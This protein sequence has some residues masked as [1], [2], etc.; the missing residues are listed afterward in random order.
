MMRRKV[1]KNNVQCHWCDP[2]DWVL[3]WGQFKSWM[4]GTIL[5]FVFTIVLAVI[6][7][8][9]HFAA[10]EKQIKDAAW[11]LFMFFWGSH[12]MHTLTR[13]QK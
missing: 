11:G 7:T 10:S 3:V 9:Y 2:V 4:L 12:T 13:K 6:L 1:K 5:I 8:K